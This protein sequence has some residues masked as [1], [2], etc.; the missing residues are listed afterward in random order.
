MSNITEAN[1][2]WKVAVLAGMAS[3]LDA[4]ALVTSGLVLGTLYASEFGLTPGEIGGLLGLETFMFAVGALFG[5]RL[6]DRFGRRRVFT[7]SMVLYAIGVAAL[8]GATGVGMLYVGVVT[9]GLAIGADLPVSLAMVN[10][11]APEGKKG[12]MVAFSQLLWGGGIIA[13]SALSTVFLSMGTTGGRILFGHLLVV[14]LIVLALR[15]TMRESAEWTAARGSVGKVSSDI[16]LSHVSQLFKP[17]VVFAMVATGLYFAA[18]NVGANTMGQ[19][20]AFVWV[21]LTGGKAETF[22]LLSLIGIPIAVLAGVFF[23][24]VVDTPARFTWLVV[25]SVLTVIGWVLPLVLGTTQVALVGTK[26]LVVL[27]GAFSGEGIYK[28]WSQELVP[29][30]L[31]TTAQGVTIAFGRVVAA[32]FAIGTPALALNSPSLLFGVIFVLAVVAALIGIFWVPRLPRASE[33]EAPPIV[34]AEVR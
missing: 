16:R 20:G 32:L 27:G 9:V 26:I 3:Y 29:T 13:S 22:A 19:F 18:W 34:V 24:R 4:G 14:A 5:G 15:L 28:V 12:R 21:N 1:H 30:L 6:G 33:I 23:L 2:P 11:E 10:E 31:R 7:L 25:G 17:P 8:V